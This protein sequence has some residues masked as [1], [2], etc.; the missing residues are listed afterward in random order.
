MIAL[1]PPHSSR[2]QN[3]SPIQVRFT[4]TLLIFVPSLSLSILVPGTPSSS[5]RSA[6]YVAGTVTALQALTNLYGR[7]LLKIQR[8]I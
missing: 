8:G 7:D 1:R 6:Y 5:E 4:F 3:I 2:N